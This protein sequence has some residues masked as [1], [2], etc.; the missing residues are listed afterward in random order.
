MELGWVGSSGCGARGVI[1]C[2]QD[3]RQDTGQ[4]AVELDSLTIKDLEARYGVTRS[5]VYTQS[6]GLQAEGY[7]RHLKAGHA[8]ARFLALD[9][10]T[11][12]PLSHRTPRSYLI[13]RRTIALMR[14]K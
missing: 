6:K 10:C 12:L 1:S 3:E 9:G 8:I 14:V 11:E 4:M 2:V 13:G 7:L 5:Q